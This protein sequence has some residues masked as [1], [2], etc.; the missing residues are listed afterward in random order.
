MT[1]ELTALAL[2]ALFQVVQLG[3]VGRF[4]ARDVGSPWSAG[5]RDEPPPRPLSRTTGR[6]MRASANHFE[7]LALFTVAVLVTTLSEQS[8]TFTAACAWV[9]L[10]ARIL[11]VPA[12]VTSIG[13]LRS[14]VWAAG[15]FATLAMIFAAL[16]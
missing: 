4:T 10:G 3:L 5:P 12:Y 2:A 6:L 9:Y 7:G 1:P 14:L 16:F 11:Y 13:P 8:T 15:F